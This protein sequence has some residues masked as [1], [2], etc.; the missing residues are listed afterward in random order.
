MRQNA[1]RRGIKLIFSSFI[2][3]PSLPSPIVLGPSWPMEE[4]VTAT[5]KKVGE[6]KRKS[7]ANRRSSTCI[8]AR[9]PPIFHALITVGWEA[10]L[11]HQLT[12][13]FL[14]A[15]FSPREPGREGG[16]GRGLEVGW[17]AT[18]GAN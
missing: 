14:V 17:V 12:P 13:P 16:R 2:L 7:S 5:V 3:C 11:G 9:T 10:P 8:S 15:H 18:R 4:N 1:L 6:G